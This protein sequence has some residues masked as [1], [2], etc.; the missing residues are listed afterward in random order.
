MKK[1]CLI[2]LMILMAAIT[3]NAQDWNGSFNQGKDYN[4]ELKRINQNT[5]SFTFNCINRRSL[6]MGLAE[7]E[8]TIDGNKAFYKDKDGSTC[9]M[10]FEIS[11]KGVKVTV[12]DVPNDCYQDAGNGIDYNGFYKK[13]VKKKKK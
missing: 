11:D 4:L 3:T 5:I 1:V 7:G 13:F 2:L 8:A 6:N 9:E 12:K 10:I